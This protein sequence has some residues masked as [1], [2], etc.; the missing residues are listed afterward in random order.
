[1]TLHP[2]RTERSLVLVPSNIALKL[3][4]QHRR[5]MSVCAGYL[6]PFALLLVPECCAV[7]QARPAASRVRTIVDSLAHAY[8]DAGHSPGLSIEVV[9]GQDTLV[10]AGYGFADLEQ[11]V[12]A[13]PSTLYEIGSITKQFTAAAVMRFVEAGRIRLDDSIAA[14]VGDLPLRWRRVSVRQL[15]N[16]TSGIPSMT[17]IGQRW[18]RRWR[19]DMPTDSLVALTAHDSMWFAPGTNWRYDNTG[20]L[21]LGILLDRVTGETFPHLAEGRLARP[22]GLV[23]TYYCDLNRVLPDRA[24]GYERDSTGWHRASYLS[25]TQPYSAGALCSTVDDL[26]RWNVL[27]AGGNV[28]SPSSYRLMTTPEGAAQSHGYGFGLVA[29]TLG[30]RRMI[31][32][33]GGINGFASANGFFPDDT[34][35]VTVLT[36]TSSWDPD[37]L[38][39]NVARAALGVP[40]VRPIRRNP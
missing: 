9:R 14:Y 4:P 25:M 33:N 20:Y 1:M 13:S 26:A 35:S 40:L 12:A 37:S 5:L 18:V 23:D 6:F 21:L 7:A 22:L 29:D 34:L 16:H 19:E 8:L 28:V 36:N 38:F 15:L 3:T 31:G 10:R 32:H 27:L 17:D 39:R 30:G 11:R 2:T 24:P